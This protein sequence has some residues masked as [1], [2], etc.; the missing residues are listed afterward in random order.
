MPDFTGQAYVLARIERNEADLSVHLLLDNGSLQWVTTKSATRSRKR[1]SAGLSALTRY[2]VVISRSGSGG[3]HQQLVEASVDRAYLKLF[4]DLR[5]MTS[6]LTIG[7]IAR[8]F[9]GELAENDALYTRYATALERVEAGT[10]D[11]ESGAEIVRFSVDV[12]ADG[13]HAIERHRC[14]LCGKRAPNERSVQFNAEAGGVRCSSCG[15]GPFV[16]TSAQ[17]VSLEAMLIGDTSQ[18]AQ[19]ML[20]WVAYMLGAHFRNAR[21]TI[22]KVTGYWAQTSATT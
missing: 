9:G 4:G 20:R 10:D 13:G 2:N 8:E 16:L 1:F 7:S 15:G 12:L 14:V 3:T 11:L 21:A 22:E 5:K 18:F 6:A 17:R 19:W